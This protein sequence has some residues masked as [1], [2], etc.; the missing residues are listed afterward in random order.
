[1]YHFR[2]GPG[3][4][5]SCPHL[6]P[7]DRGHNSN[8]FGL[9]RRGTEITYVCHSGRCQSAS[10]RAKKKL[11]RLPFPNLSIFSGDEGGAQ[12]TDRLQIYTGHKLV[13]SNEKWYIWTGSVWRVDPSGREASN[14]CCGELNKI[15]A[16]YQTDLDGSKSRCH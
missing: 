10:G 4:R 13:F 7:G 9:L 14:V 5:E 2:N 12:I 16:A 1:M 6:K 8:N 3:G 15:S 11:G